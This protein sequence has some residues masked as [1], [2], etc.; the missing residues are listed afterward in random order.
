MKRI[1]ED[2]FPFKYLLYFLA[3]AIIISIAGYLIYN[4]R[5]NAIE[6]ELYRHVATI[7]EIKL[8]QIEKEQLQRKKAI[9]SFLLLPEIKN[10]LK[11]LFTKKQS[12]ALLNNIN[13]WTNEIKY[14]FEFVSINIFN[15]NADLLYS[16]DSTHAI[17]DHFLKH[18]LVVMLQKDSSALS[19]LYLGDN[20]KL[21]Q[22]IITPIK[23]A[24]VIVGYLWTEISFF[25]YLH[26]IIS[27]TKQETEDVEY[28][29]LK[30]QSDLGFILRDIEEDNEFKIRTIPISKQDK[31]E[32]ESFIKTKD[33]FNDAK[34]KGSKIF[35]SVNEIPGTDW[36][37]LAKINQAKVAEST[38]N[39]ALLVSIISVLLII[40]SASITYA[41]WKRSRLHFL[42]RTFALRKEKDA[43]TERYTSL[44]KYA[45][46]MILSVDKNG[47]ILEANQ[48]A[49]NTYGY[50]TDELLKME[51]LD[52]SFDRKKD[53]EV[54]F[55][56]INNPNGILFETNHKRKNG[57]II[58]V[59][60]SAKLI[61]QGD[62]EILLAIIRDNTERK[63][64][65]LDL[66]LAKDKAEE[67]DRLKTTF[68]SN[69]SHELNT[70]MSGIIGFSELL[71]S[72]MDNKNHREMAK[73]IHNSGK[74]LNETLNSILD[75]SKI[76]SQKLDLKISSIDL[77][78]MIKE[79]KYVFS[80]S[81]NK[82]GLKFNILY[83]Q[84][85]VFIKSDQNIVH[86]I[87]C[88]I[89]DNAVKYTNEGSI[90]INITENDKNAI[91]KVTDT[92]IGIPKENLNQI[93]EPFRQG[94][95]GLN[96]KFEGMGLGLTITKKY[97][98]ILGGKL[99]IESEHGSGTAI[100]IILPK[101]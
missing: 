88:S 45:N 98:E 62:E 94:S 13:K 10:D 83:D 16:S 85:K 53:V 58:P 64:L 70:P 14:D 20:K 87:L 15:K 29:L 82:K 43:L 47:K 27:Y 37:L 1:T 95:E 4:D 75:L 30:K 99:N 35:A 19:N 81:V 40:L 66:I 7:K 26:P 17:F 92:G 41:I 71:L 3:V 91:I 2:S 42:T 52:L 93:F 32:L 68:L 67:M 21:L 28:I 90:T 61:K 55:S 44:T 49:F 80:D 31:N 78:T 60:I 11:T 65:E 73:I 74:R 39:A 89:I 18:E 6:D 96:R 77:I 84:E 79:C 54:I 36:I 86:K 101:N 23:N 46:D 34:F 63:K 56:S 22:A 59:E 76:E 9:A 50:S 8:A 69:M 72:E 33:F 12:P 57:T 5:K 100:E 51:L 25:E 48:K 38:K 97:V 24:N